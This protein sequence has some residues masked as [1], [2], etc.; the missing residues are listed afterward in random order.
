MG[1]SE[2]QKDLI[3]VK[4]ILKSVK[5]MEDLSF[6]RDLK[7]QFISK[8]IVLISPTD[9]TFIQVQN[10]LNELEQK[11]TTKITSGYLFK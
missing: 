4:L 8:Y 11:Y 9:K 2:Y 3:Y 1:Q 6:A 5:T 10:E 7:R